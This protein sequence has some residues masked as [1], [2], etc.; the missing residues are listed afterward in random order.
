MKVSTIKVKCRL[1]GHV[2]EYPLLSD[3]S[4]GQF[5]YSSQNGQSYRYLFG[6]NNKTWDFVSKIV[7]GDINKVKNEGE[8]I[9]AILGRISD[10][11]STTEYYQN[12]KIICQTCGRKAWHVYRNNILGYVEVKEMTFDRFERL[13]LDEKENEVKLLIE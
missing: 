8:V 3:F 5:I 10:K 6:L 9:Q 2:F 13:T 7:K 1:W 4:Y 11:D 12:N